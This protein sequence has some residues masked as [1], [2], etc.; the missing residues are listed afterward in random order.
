MII[1]HCQRRKE[2]EREK[3]QVSPTPYPSRKVLSQMKKKIYSY[4]FNP[5][6]CPN[7]M[8]EKSVRETNNTDHKPCN[9]N[10]H[11]CMHDCYVDEHL[12]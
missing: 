6:Y 11:T 12:K 10:D 8:K 9:A 7:P 2:D 5:K 3:S 1:L 4:T